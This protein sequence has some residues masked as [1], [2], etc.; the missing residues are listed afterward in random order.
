MAVRRVERVA[1]TWFVPVLLIVVVPFLVTVWLIRADR[2][3]CERGNEVRENQRLVLE[4]IAASDAALAEH[5]GVRSVAGVQ[6]ALAA[7]VAGERARSLEVVGCGF[8]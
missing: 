7:R 1:V 3:T 6:L 4:S 5:V 2:A 8:P